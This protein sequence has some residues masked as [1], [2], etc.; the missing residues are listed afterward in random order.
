[1]IWEL[2]SPVVASWGATDFALWIGQ[3]I[4]R[5][6][7]LFTLH[8]FGLVL[9]IGGSLFVNL[10]LLN[11]VLPNKPAR[12]VGQTAFPLITLGL[13]LMVFSGGLIFLG[14]A[15]AYFAGQWFRLKM[16]LLLCAVLFHY[17][18]LRPVVRADGRFGPWVTKGAAVVAVLLW[19]GVGWSGRFIAF[20]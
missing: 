6:Y 10:R 12:E 11:L 5:I 7:L 4:G 1:M 3:S 19:F 9:L 17:L 2:L 20:F 15:E 14:G 16:V 8:L 18:L 13:V